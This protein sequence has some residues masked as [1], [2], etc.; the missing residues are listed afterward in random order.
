MP[1]VDAQQRGAVAWVISAARRM[2]PSPPITSGQLAVRGC[3]ALVVGDLQDVEGPSAEPEVG[4]LVGQQPDAIPWAVSA[5]QNGA[6][7]LAGLLRPVWA[8]SEDPADGAGSA[9]AGRCHGSTSHPPPPGPG[10]RTTRS[11]SS[12]A[13]RR[14]PRR[15]QRKNSTLP[16]GPGSGLVVT[17]RAPQPARRRLP[18]PR[19]PPRPAARVADHAALADPVLADLELRLDHQRQVAVGRGDRR[20]ARRAPAPAR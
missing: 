19:T 1:E 7:D 9:P 15:S 12:S 4:G 13:D 8:S 3:V 18:R 10:A 14:R 20:A 16:D 5:L 17:I 6:G 11:M 2:V